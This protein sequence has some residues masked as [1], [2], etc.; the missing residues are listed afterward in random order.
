MSLHRP[1]T[2]DVTDPHMDAP[3]GAVMDGYERVGLIWYDRLVYGHVWLRVKGPKLDRNRSAVIGAVSGPPWNVVEYRYRSPR[4]EPYSR[5]KHTRRRPRVS[6][7]R[8]D[9]KRFLERFIPIGES[10]N[11]KLPG[12][13]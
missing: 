5:G 10:S 4:D 8:M 11:L 7:T 13:P 6:Y 9:E 12:V 1:R 3:D 2:R